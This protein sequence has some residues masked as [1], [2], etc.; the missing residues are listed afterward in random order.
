MPLELSASPT[1]DPFDVSARVVWIT[2]ASSGIGLHLCALMARR[3]A[4]VIATSRT[5]RASRAL[6]DIAAIAGERFLVLDADVSRPASIRSAVAQ[7]SQAF[8]RVDVLINNAGTAL[9]QDAAE[10]TDEQWQAVLATNLTGPFTMCRAVLPAM[11]AGGSIVNVSSVAAHKSIRTLSAYSATKAGLEQF[12]RVLALEAAP[13]GIRVNSVAPGYI[14][15]P[16]N[17]EYLDGEAASKLRRAIPVQRFGEP[18]DLDGVMLLLASRASAY[19]TGA[20]FNVDG[21]LSL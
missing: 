5:A 11:G 3:G 14:R 4:T 9:E 6:A 8:N 18:A 17:T 19:I 21:G 7:A 1:S 10:T 13:R 20:C 2:G 16:M 12:G 15:T